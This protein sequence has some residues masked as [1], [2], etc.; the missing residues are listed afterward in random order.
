MKKYAIVFL[1]TSLF[2]T[3]WV[4]VFSPE[5]FRLTD[6][7]SKDGEGALVVGA[8][9]AWIRVAS[10][11]AH[12]AQPEASAYLNPAHSESRKVIAMLE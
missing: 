9:C 8:D 3:M 11:K 4:E 1:K 6:A 7:T 10:M 12:T 2:G 5:R